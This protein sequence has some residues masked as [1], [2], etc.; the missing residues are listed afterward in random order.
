M[1]ET[2]QLAETAR[3]FGYAFL[4]SPPAV[5][6]DDLVELI[7]ASLAR[8]H[9]VMPLQSGAGWIEVLTADPGNV[10]LAAELSFA[11][12][13]E[14][15]LVVCD[16]G[17]LRELVRQ[18]FGEEETTGPAGLTRSSTDEWTSSADNPSTEELASIAGQAPVIQFVNQALT[19]AIRDRAS[20]IHFEP[21]EKSFRVRFR[22]DGVLYEQTPPP[23]TLALP[24]ASRLKVLANLDIAERR[25]PQDG[26]I[27]MNVAGRGVD[28]RVS[29]MPTQFGESVVLRVLDRMAVQL[30]L[31]GLGLPDSI[32]GDVQRSLRRPN[33]IILVTGPT[34]SG[35]TTTLYSGLREIST[36]GLKVLT[37]EDPVEYEIE[38]ILQVPVNPV[39]GLTFATALRSL[40]R[41]DPD[42][43]MVGEIRDLE[44]A[45]IA[46]QAALTGHLVLST[47]HTNDAPS[48]ITRL[49]DMGVEP[50][51]LASSIEAV[52]AQR[53][54]RRICP[55]CREPDQ[56]SPALA[57]LLEL[58]SP[59]PPDRRFLRGRGCPECSGTGYRGRIGIFE[60]LVFTEPLREL[61]AQRT[62][63]AGIRQ[64]GRKQGMRTLREEAWRAVLNGDTTLGEMARHT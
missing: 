14:V 57:S 33:G 25:L 16:A 42:V 62:P 49:I 8:R 11:L 45:Q 13:R 28:L 64:R 43:I 51:L 40:L 7:P 1:E 12:E 35:K 24:I 9:Q 60:W 54:V 30:D 29:S 59:T 22:I 17:T 18:H 61:V 27:R 23:R 44:T 48:A 56:P 2:D 63:V 37:I 50:F 41:Q 21:F 26:R 3:Q 39:A 38:G 32:K 55:H 58:E 34:G 46:I 31:N 19:Q 53:L 15:R 10:E 36:P 5:F 6:S 4:A 20:D 52:L 47:L